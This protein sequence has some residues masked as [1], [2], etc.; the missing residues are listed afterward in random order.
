M[1]GVLQQLDKAPAD[2]KGRLHHFIDALVIEPTAMSFFCLC[3]KKGRI[4]NIQENI[5][6]GNSETHSMDHDFVLERTYGKMKLNA[7]NSSCQ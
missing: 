2:D 3:F 6:T 7:F 5:G 1:I 4:L